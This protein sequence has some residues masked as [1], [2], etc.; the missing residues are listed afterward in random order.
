MPF[1]WIPAPAFARDRLCAGMTA[2]P[3]ENRET[4]KI[5]NYEIFSYFSVYSACL[6][7]KLSGVSGWQY[8]EWKACPREEPVLSEEPVPS[9]G[10]DRDGDIENIPVEP[11]P[12]R[13]RGR[14]YSFLAGTL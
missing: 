9:E 5:G 12:S 1:L 2:C 4:G 11:A 14:G 8:R 13:S 7:V 10:R 6:V 3:G